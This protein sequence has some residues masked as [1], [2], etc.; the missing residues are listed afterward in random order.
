MKR[1]TV[2]SK[3]A[4]PK[5]GKQKQNLVNSN[6]VYS[7]PINRSYAGKNKFGVS[8]S[9]HVSFQIYSK[10]TLEQMQQ[11][12]PGSTIQ[13]IKYKADAGV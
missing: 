2:K 6:E 11:R 13:A 4:A 5:R 7:G 12:Y 1:G 8:G 3:E 9:G 10:L